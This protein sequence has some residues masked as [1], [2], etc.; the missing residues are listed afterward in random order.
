MSR[1][2]SAD[3]LEDAEYRARLAPLAKAVLPRAEESPF[4][5]AW[6]VPRRLRRI[7]ATCVVG[8]A[9]VLASAWFYVPWRHVPRPRAAPIPAAASEHPVVSE[10]PATVQA[11]VATP[12]PQPAP[13]QTETLTGILLDRGNAAMADG[14]ITAARLLFQR[15][16][17]AGSAE[18]AHA[19][20]TTYDV[21]SLLAVGARATYANPVLA[22]AWYS[23]ASELASDAAKRSLPNDG[24]TR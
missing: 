22:A 23:R 9:V 20:G 19:L 16:A 8:A 15:A 17:D 10:H 7:V 14:D 3:E 13:T 6:P 4:T 2:L 18:A 24:T 5:P 21:Q 11:A 1:P 12:A